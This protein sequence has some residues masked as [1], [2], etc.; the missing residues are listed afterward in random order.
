MGFLGR[1]PQLLTGGLREKSGFLIKLY[2]CDGRLTFNA[3]EL[4]GVGFGKFSDEAAVV[5]GQEAFAAERNNRH[6]KERPPL[7]AF[8]QVVRVATQT[9]AAG[10]KP[11]PQ[12][13][14]N[15]FPAD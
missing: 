14:N 15:S 7:G 1:V 2:P 11:L 12:P 9:V 4:R 6:E 8:L 3:E 10:V 13:L 5:A